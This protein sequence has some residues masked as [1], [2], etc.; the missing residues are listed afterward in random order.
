MVDAGLDEYNRASSTIDEVRTLHVI[1]TD[2]DGNVNGGALGRTWGQCCELQQL[3][4][5]LEERGNSIGTQLM[6][7][8]EQE[9]VERGC[10]LIYL[11]TFSFQAPEFYRKRGYT[12]VLR[13]AVRSG[14]EEKITMH[15]HIGVACSTQ[16]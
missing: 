15:K 8:F 4:V 12:E 11:D 16:G 1:A 5:K 7:V 13:T 6:D 10:Q 14:G 9:A 2:N 3:W